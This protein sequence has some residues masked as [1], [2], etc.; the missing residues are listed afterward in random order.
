MSQTTQSH[1]PSMPRFRSSSVVYPS[2]LNLDHQY[3]PQQSSQSTLSQPAIPVT[4][5]S[6]AYASS[7][8]TGGFQ[9]AP[10][11]PTAEFQI[12]RTPSL[13]TEARPGT[14][15][16]HMANISGP[17]TAPMAASQDFS[18]AYQ[19]TI[20]PRSGNAQTTQTPETQHSET[21]GLAIPHTSDEEGNSSHPPQHQEGHYSRVRHDGYGMDTSSTHIGSQ[22]RKRTFSMSKNYEGS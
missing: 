21:V 16:Y 6:S 11:L 1:N 22:S 18:S 9:S 12:P 13:G 2:G 17:M 4:P 7:Y 5:R 20:S 15:D 10:L 14:G 19:S 8:S 3:R